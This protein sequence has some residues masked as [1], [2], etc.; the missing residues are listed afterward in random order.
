MPE[1][2]GAFSGSH[3][4]GESSQ[5]GRRSSP[6]TE[7]CFLGTL[8]CRAHAATDVPVP[9]HL[10]PPM[11]ELWHP[12]QSTFPMRC[13]KHLSFQCSETPFTS[14][15][16]ATLPGLAHQ[17]SYDARTIGRLAPPTGPSPCV[18]PPRCCGL[19]HITRV[20][21]GDYGHIMSTAS[22]TY[23]SQNTPSLRSNLTSHPHHKEVTHHRNVAVQ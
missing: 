7:A 11:A 5:D 2:S 3:V 16:S 20:T 13:T 22:A 4:C 1:R 9:V 21:S 10:T 15:A 14:R 19:D 12:G 8:P 23:A 17:K 18:H 6:R